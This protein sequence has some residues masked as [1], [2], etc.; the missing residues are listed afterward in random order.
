MAG[1]THT[2]TSKPTLHRRPLTLILYVLVQVEQRTFLP[3]IWR[4]TSLSRKW[5]KLFLHFGHT[6]WLHDASI[7]PTQFSH[8]FTP[9]HE[10]TCGLRHGRRQTGHV[11]SSGKGSTKSQS[12]PPATAIF[13]IR[14]LQKIEQRGVCSYSLAIA[15][16]QS[17]TVTPRF[18][19][20]ADIDK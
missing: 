5:A 13:C 6:G 7:G 2:A 18:E 19:W 16:R 1:N 10:R 3:S 15:E 20:K 8:I 11:S 12:Y 14:F 17:S 4:L 9:Q